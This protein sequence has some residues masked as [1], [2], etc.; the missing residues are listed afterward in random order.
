MNRFKNILFIIGVIA[1]IVMIFTFDVSFTQLWGYI[2]QAGYWLI[3]ILALW[4]VLYLMNAWSWHVILRGSGP[5]PVSYLYLLRITV[6]G[7]ALNY[8]TPVGLLGGEPYKII[9]L[10]P[11]VGVQRATSSVLLFA[12]MY[13]FAHFCFWTSAIIIYLLLAAFRLLPL[14]TAIA[15]V[16]A[17]SALFCAL[18]IYLFIRGYRYGMALRT[19]RLLTRIP[20]IRGWARRF[21][22]DHYDDLTK[23]D[24]Q[25]AQLHSQSR[26]T[27][28]LS[29]TIEYIGRVCQSFEIFF[30]LILFH[31][32]PDN[33][34][35]SLSMGFLQ[36]FLILSFTS[37]FANILGF[38]PLQLG[39]REGGFALSVSAL[40]MT[41]A[42]G[43]FISIICRVRELF[44]AVIG[45][46]LMRVKD[47][48]PQT[49]NCKP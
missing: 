31:S 1:V 26:P 8:T 20:G 39:G 35:A 37:L 30:M 40:G 22:T 17:F 48:A 24:R 49:V 19:I 29:L 12:M 45:L 34:L 5:C 3:A 46:I 2:Q 14:N 21:L 41:S 32:L 7:F 44:W 27:F 43:L 47:R 23:I 4:G 38:L 10:T 18:G 33:S 15:V 16:L 6:S 36:S 25:I 11:H 13:V 42:L 28:Y 9:Q